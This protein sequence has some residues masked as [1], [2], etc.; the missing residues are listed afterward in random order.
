MKKFYAIIMMVFAGLSAS[1]QSPIDAYTISQQ[2]LKGT[3][4]FMSMG[5]A[6]GALGADLSSL[7]QNPGGIGVYRSSE[8]GITF[9]IDAQSANSNYQGLKMN[10]SQTR[11]YVNNVG[12]VGT[13]RLGSNAVPNLNLGFTY[14][15]GVAFNRHFKG[16]IGNL[17][18]SLS[19]YIAGIAN[20]YNLTEADLRSN[21]SYDPYVNANRYIPWTTVLAYDSY[22]ISPEETANGGTDWYGQFGNGTSGNA[23]Y[24]VRESG[25]ID[26]YNIA[27]GGNFANRVFWGMNFGITTLDYTIS[28]D[29]NEN[30]TNAYVLDPDLNRVR[31]MDAQWNVNNLYNIQGTG[32]N[33]SLGV[34]VRPVQALRIGFA[35]H[36]PTWYS[37]T[38]NFGAEQIDY[39]YPFDSNYAITNDGYSTSNN[40]RLATPWKIIASVAGVIGTKGIISFDYEWNGMKN[41]RYSSANYYDD[42]N[43][44]WDGYSPY[45]FDSNPTPEEETNEMIKTM[46]KD[47]HTIRIGGEY[48]VLDNLSLRLGYSFTSSP[49]TSEAKDN[50]ANVPTSGTMANFRLDNEKHYIT[51]GIGYHVKGFYVDA[52]YVYKHMSS[53][54]HPF[55]ADPMDVSGTAMVPKL[56]FDNSQ[57]VISLGYKF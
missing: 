17:K 10:T 25:G 43:N 4:R 3:A 6:F 38:E 14:N 54:F 27:L 15:K 48:R 20:N 1:A 18:T 37:L 8:V 57:V 35:F 52:A 29:Y 47:T 36:T 23:F 51:A 34:I 49:V 44:W 19:N 56:N 42:Y 26:E 31:Q 28:S 50:L 12:I 21:G 5:G 7:S 13:L 22:L 33:Y 16:G 53:S 40:V 11:F 32:F 9:D 46:Y 45:A 41:M 55:S 30:L 39:R 24:N 2:D